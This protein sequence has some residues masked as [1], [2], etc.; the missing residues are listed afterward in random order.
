M[1]TID[2]EHLI[3]EVKR[4]PV[5]WD[6]NHK[7]YNQRNAKLLAWQEVF[8]NLIVDWTD[9][10]KYDRFGKGKDIQNRWTNIRD[11][12]MREIKYEKKVQK[13]LALPKKKYKFSHLLGFLDQ[14]KQIKDKGSDQS[15]TDI[16]ESP[17]KN[18]SKVLNVNIVDLKNQTESLYADSDGKNNQ[19][20]GSNNGRAK[21]FKPNNDLSSVQFNMQSDSSTMDS[22]SNN[23]T[24]I[25]EE[26]NRGRLNITSETSK[27][28][29]PS[30]QSVQEYY[31]IN[32][33]YLS[34]SV[35]ISSGISLPLEQDDD[36]MFVLSLLPYF[37][38][39]NEERKLAAR[40]EMSTL[41]QKMIYKKC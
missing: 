28:G 39:L 8:A 13:G 23:H 1:N 24:P 12:Y 9:M 14:S 16:E 25:R 37:K 22:D 41:L 10:S 31:Q 33:E 36:K 6:Q 34:P 40:I 21:R 17:V 11:T 7:Y 38:K 4:R 15:S 30:N 3:T 18:E 19:G 26:T 29:E 32:P 5:L 2:S 35:E 20:R 27:N